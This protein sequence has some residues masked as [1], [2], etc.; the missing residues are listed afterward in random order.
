MVL[1]SYLNPEMSKANVKR[2]QET[3]V[4]SSFCCLS[5]MNIRSWFLLALHKTHRSL[6]RYS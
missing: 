5:D 3:A 6:I 1:L 2:R 4:G